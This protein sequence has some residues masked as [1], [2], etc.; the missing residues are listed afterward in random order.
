MLFNSVGFAI[1]FPVVAIIYFLLER[2]QELHRIANFWLLASS[3]F[4]Y[5][6]Q[7]ARYAGLLFAAT[8]ITYLGG[9]L[10]GSGK[11]SRAGRIAALVISITANLSMLFF[12]KYFNFACS[13]IGVEP[14][15]KIIL[16]VGISF[17]IFQSLT[18]VFDIYR[19]DTKPERD[20]FKYALFVS[21]FPVLLAGPIER[22]KHL[23]HQFDEMHHFDYDRTRHGLIRMLYGF[24][25]KL[26]IAQRLAIAVNLIYDHY[27]DCTGYQLLLGTVLYAF[28]IYCDFASYSSIAVGCA[29]ILGFS[30]IENFRQP[31]LAASCSDLWRRWHVSL[32]SWFRDYLYIPLGGSR[33]PKW[34]KYLNVMIVF[35]TSGLWHGASWTYIIW[36][37]LSGLFQV[38]GEIL[39]PLRTAAVKRLP[40]HNKYTHV[41]HHILQILITF[42]L[43]STS[44]VFFRS[45]DLNAALTITA[46]IFTK[47]EPASI[48]STSLFS[49]GL[50]VKNFMFLAVSMA[51]LFIYDIINEKQKDAAAYIAALKAPLRWVIYYA[52][53]VMILASASLGSQQ[54]IY[55]KF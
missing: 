42:G 31:F 48:M 14:S 30:L 6:C 1:F 4:Y 19:G 55:F 43:F 38:L 20:F 8:L 26:V 27:S 23:L 47:F 45:P 54:F 52:A 17:Y 5:M 29:D 25:L 12:F 39:K 11:T 22:S 13:I 7:D 40:V 3:Y 33:V 2:K 53:A 21:F 32:N 35:T 36:G 16:P 51:M 44:L 9:N 18:Y 50:G 37:A 15:L 46:K 10:I 34:R 28:Q 41:I 49:L 24:F